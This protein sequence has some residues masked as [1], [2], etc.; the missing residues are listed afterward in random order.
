MHNSLASAKNALNSG[1][2]LQFS[3]AVVFS[4]APNEI[5]LKELETSCIRVALPT[6]PGLV[7]HGPS[8]E[9]IPGGNKFGLFAAFGGPKTDGKNFF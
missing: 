8:G 5:K 7:Q 6:V 9:L 3:L 1:R 4:H 2:D